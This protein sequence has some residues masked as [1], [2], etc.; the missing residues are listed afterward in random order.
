MTGS[1][2]LLVDDDELNRFTLCKVMEL[3]GFDVTVAVNVPDALRHI[4]TDRFD[5]LVSDPHMPGA[6]DGLTV[7]S[8][9]RHANPSAVTILLSANPDMSAAANALLLQTAEILLKPIPVPKLVDTIQKRMQKG[10]PITP[11]IESVACI[12]ERSMHKTVGNWLDRVEAD[13]KLTTV[14]L[15]RQL[16]IAYVPKILADLVRRLRMTDTLD[17]TEME[18]KA[19][20]EHGLLRREQG[21]SASMM[22]RES[23]LLQVSIFETLQENLCT[24]DFSVLLSQV[25]VIA[26][27]VDS[28]LSQSLESYNAEFLVDSLSA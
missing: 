2:V 1:R 18:S 9:M 8:A 12:L 16:R 5:A 19:A 25:M 26:D 6:A 4:T 11:L 23:R 28:Q 21:Y 17:S 15:S 7:V 13:I 27:E 22:V 24:L 14:G 3:H 10:P 20:R